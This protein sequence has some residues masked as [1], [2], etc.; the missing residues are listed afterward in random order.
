M[1]APRLDTIGTSTA[2]H[3]RRRPSPQATPSILCGNYRIMYYLDKKN[4]LKKAF[5]HHVINHGM[6]ETEPPLDWKFS[7]MRNDES[8][9]G[10]SVEDDAKKEVL[11]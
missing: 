3:Y 5:S 10:Q 6:S 8:K 9:V 4:A 2:R 1:C 7:R 11:A